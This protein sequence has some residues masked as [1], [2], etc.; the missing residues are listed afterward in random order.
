M[1]TPR[2]HETCPLVVDHHLRDSMPTTSP[3]AA[4]PLSG[5]KHGLD[6]LRTFL[7]ALVI[8]HHTAIVYG[9]SG[10]WEIRSRCFPPASVLLVPFKAIDQ[11]FFMALF[12]YLSGHFTRVQMTKKRV[13][14][15]AVIRS[16][17]LRILLPAVVYTARCT[18]LASHGLGLG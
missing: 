9:G 15:C 13:S 14:R 2:I 17:L 5:R 18:N 7:T 6:S 12:F 8:L 11:T 4:T 3:R 16:R 1:A 10:K